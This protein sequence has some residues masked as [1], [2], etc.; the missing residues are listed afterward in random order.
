MVNMWV[1]EE[2][3]SG[4]KLTEIINTE[5]TNVK[6]LPGHTLPRNVVGLSVE[7][8]AGCVGGEM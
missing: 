7:P 8:A 6:Y 4:R 3:V 1:Y 5:H 2:M